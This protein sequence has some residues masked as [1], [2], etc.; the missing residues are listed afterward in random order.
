MAAFLQGAKKASD[1]KDMA[2]LHKCL[3]RQQP[4]WSR[5]V[6]LAVHCLAPRV[7]T[8]ALVL[9]GH[10]AAEHGLHKHTIPSCSF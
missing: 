8:R 5:Y 2:R 9:A 6:L 3:A 10:R 1:L 4:N 7:C